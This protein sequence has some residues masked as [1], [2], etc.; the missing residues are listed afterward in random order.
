MMKH[1]Y[2]F[3]LVAGVLLSGCVSLKQVL[4]PQGRDVPGGRNAITT[5]AQSE[6]IAGI[7]QSN[8]AAATGGGLLIALIDAGVN[9]SRAKTAEEAITPV[10]DSLAD[11]NFDVKALATTEAVI[12]KVPWLNVK[13]TEANKDPTNARF[14]KAL[15]QTSGAQL[16]SVTYDYMLDNNFQQLKV[17]ANVALLP[18]KNTKRSKSDTRMLLKNAEFTRPFICVVPLAA[19]SEKMP[20][21]AARWAKNGGIY[22]EQKIDQALSKLAVV[23]E[24]GLQFT[25][26][27]QATLKKKKSKA[28]GG[29]NG[30]VIEQDADGTLL[31]TP[32]GQWIYVFNAS[33][34]S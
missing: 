7:Q 8:I 32:I 16:L 13:A 21:N 23:V 28:V 1:R 14:T 20:E 25:E 24:K 5:V 2:V 17:G 19:A 3:A 33:S 26:A 34:A 27:Q 10:R 15:D 11:Y 22:A 18:T 4:P 12:K 9:N 6:I 29:F 30:K 31:Q